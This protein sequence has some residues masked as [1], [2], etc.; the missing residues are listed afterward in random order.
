MDGVVP[1]GGLPIRKWLTYQDLKVS[2]FLR[3]TDTRIQ[4]LFEK[5]NQYLDFQEKISKKDKLTLANSRAN[6]LA[7]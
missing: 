4:M 7:N 2:H 5:H 1:W 3:E 6:P